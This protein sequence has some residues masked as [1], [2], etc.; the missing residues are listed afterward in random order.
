MITDYTNSQNPNNSR[1]KTSIKSSIGK[2]G[3]VKS[4]SKAIK[5][6]SSLSSLDEDDFYLFSF[7]FNTKADVN[8]QFKH[9]QHIYS[10]PSKYIP[11]KA[12]KNITAYPYEPFDDYYLRILTFIP[13][14]VKEKTFKELCRRNWYV[15]QD[16][17][18]Y[19]SADLTLYGPSYR[20]SLEQFGYRTRKNMHKSSEIKAGND[21]N[22]HSGTLIKYLKRNGI[23]FEKPAYYEKPW[24]D[25]D[26]ALLESIE[27]ITDVEDLNDKPF[28]LPVFTSK[29]IKD[30][31][32]DEPLKEEPVCLRLIDKQE[33][34][35]WAD[36]EDIVFHE[37]DRQ[38]K[39]SSEEEWSVSR[40]KPLGKPVP[41]EALA[42]SLGVDSDEIETSTH[43]TYSDVPKEPTSDL[44]DLNWSFVVGV[45]V[46]VAATGLLISKLFSKK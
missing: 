32:L 6:L 7:D 34:Q 30:L 16:M 38:E 27:D 19:L 46:G 25:A 10:N 12:R 2:T 22:A 39:E 1:S 37:W 13:C 35:E 14:S 45:M 18:C 26:A 3:Q 31:F 44:Q 41:L 33:E 43:D 40:P 9:A 24:I 29:E 21:S 15:S 5:A 36:M 23:E 11:K 4:K 42:D 17:F 8:A 20:E 28:S